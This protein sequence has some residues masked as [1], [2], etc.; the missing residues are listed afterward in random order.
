MLPWSRCC[1]C[2]FWLKYGLYTV[3]FLVCASGIVAVVIGVCAFLDNEHRAMLGYLP[4]LPAV[5]L[6]AVGVVGGLVGFIGCVGAA[7]ESLC[8]LKLFCVASSLLFVCEIVGGTLMFT[9]MDYVHSVLKSH[10]LN[11]IINYEHSEQLQDLID[12]IQ[13]KL[14]CCGATDYH[15]WDANTYFNCETLTSTKS[16]CTVPMSCCGVR[17]DFYCGLRSRPYGEPLL[18]S[19]VYRQGCT[20]PL[21]Q[22]FKSGLFHVSILAFTVGISEVIGVVLANA[23]IR[24]TLHSHVDDE[25][26][27]DGGI[28]VMNDM[29]HQSSLTEND[30]SKLDFSLIVSVNVS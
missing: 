7:R 13:Q 29:T 12:Y 19:T 15:D 8:L 25:T 11:A 10:L 16:H 3:N 6:A 22:A 28:L 9:L 20:D 23:L 18:D 17:G 2:S 27:A 5:L 4:A 14:E 1:Q 26:L 30:G 21:L 24:S